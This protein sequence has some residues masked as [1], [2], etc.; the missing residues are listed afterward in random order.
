[1]FQNDM[2]KQNL[3][4]RRK[5]YSVSIKTLHNNITAGHQF[6]WQIAVIIFSFFRRCGPI[7]A[8]ASSFMRFLYR[9]RLTKVG[10]T[11]LDEWSTRRRDLYLTTHNNHDRHPCP[12]GIRTRNLSRRAAP[13][14]RRRPRGHWDRQQSDYKFAHFKTIHG[15]TAYVTMWLISHR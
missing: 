12:G 5:L 6:V 9:T 2:V 11:P 7:R 8:T 13:D 14:S 1:M 4:C 3:Y 10:R 15:T